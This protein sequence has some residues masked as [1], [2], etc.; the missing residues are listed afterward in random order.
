MVLIRFRARRRCSLTLVLLDKDGI[1]KE[2]PPPSDVDYL[3][4]P[5]TLKA[6][7]DCCNEFWWL[8]PYVAKAIWRDQLPLAKFVTENILRVQLTKMLGWGVVVARK[9]PVAL[10]KHG[11]E[12]SRYLRPAEWE[13]FKATYVN[14][15]YGRMWQALLEMGVLFR[16]TAKR[17]ACELGYAYPER[18]DQLVSEF[19][20]RIK[21]LPVGATEI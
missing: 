9:K 7:S 20:S 1:L 12:L 2:V 19:T 21:R 13:S 17:I 18:E 5:P 4:Y 3:T 10:G 8:N 15:D 16:T 14:S 11:T 6:F